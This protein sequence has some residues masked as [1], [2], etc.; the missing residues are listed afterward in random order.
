MIRRSEVVVTRRKK[1]INDEITHSGLLVRIFAKEA[2][3][4]KK[5]PN[6]IGPEDPDS[7]N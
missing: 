2:G 6:P 4:S 1:E 7:V 5:S 3:R